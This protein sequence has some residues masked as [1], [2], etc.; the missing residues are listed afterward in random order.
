MTRKDY[1][2][3]AARIKEAKTKAQEGYATTKEDAIHIV[4]AGLA[5]VLKK[6]NDRFD[7]VRFMEACG[8]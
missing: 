5:D 6:D 1:I 3:I 2:A 4:A 8:F 7:S